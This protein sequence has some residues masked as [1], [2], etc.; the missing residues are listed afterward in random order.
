MKRKKLE[1]AYTLLKS[2]V[3]S[4]DETPIYGMSYDAFSKLIKIIDPK[5]SDIKIKILFKVLD[6]NQDRYLRN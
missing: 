3:S 4:R 5:K 6:F 2:K 1:C